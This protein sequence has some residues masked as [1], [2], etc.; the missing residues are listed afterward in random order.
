MP[1]PAE[2]WN[3]LAKFETSE[4]GPLAFRALV[5]LL[6]TW[7]GDDQ[8]AA[9]EVA[10]KLLSKWPDDVRLAPWSW[11]KAASKGVAPATWRLVRA[12]Q[13]GSGHLTK[14]RVSLTRLARRA[15]LEHIT[16][17]VLPR[18]SDDRELSLLYHCPGM[19]PALKRLQATD[20]SDDGDVRALADSPLWQTLE[21]FEIEDLTESFAHLK[22]ASRIVPR[23][24]RLRHVRHL[25]L[26]SPDLIA[27]W[28]SGTLPR[29][30]SAAVFIRSVDEARTL[31]ARKEL[32]RLTSLSISFRCGFSGSSPFEPYQGTIIE[33]D[34]AAADAFFSHA[35]LDRLKS[36]AIVG[37]S[38]GYWGREG[39]GRL[40]L[41]AL[42][43]SGLLQR[44]KHLRLKLLPL[45]DKGVAALAPALGKQLETLELVDV[46]CKGGGA[47]A[48]IDSPCMASLRRL[49]LSAN[50]IDAGHAVRLA[51]VDMPRLQ[52][53]DLS[54]PHVNP[55]YWNV[56]QQPILDAGACAWANSRNAMR[57]R[58][59]RLSNCFLS[60]EA[61]RA[62][63]QSPH[64]RRLEQL[65]LSH[66]S[67][68]AAAIS[69]AVVESPLWRTLRELGL[70]DCRL[71]NDA[72]DALA[73]VAAAPALR[74][75]EL[76][77]NSIG[78]KGA[79]ALARW[80]VLE[81]V[82]R[83]G[84]HDNVIG[85]DGLTALAHSPHL[86]R[87]VELDLEQ[88]CWNS[89]TF[90]FSDQAAR[91]LA[92][93]RSLSRLD[94]L[95]SGCVDEYHGAAYS[96]GFTKEGLDLMRKADWMRPACRAACSDFSKI[97]EYSECAPF[98]EAAELDDHDFRRHPPTLNEA[99]AK[100]TKHKMRQIRSPAAFKPA[101][102]DD[103][104]PRISPLPP[105]P[106]S[107]EPDVI[108]GIAFLD[109][110]PVT[111]H[112]FTLRLPLE[113]NER[114]LPNP[115]G[116]V[117]SDT[118]ASVFRAA[119]LGSFQVGG[120]SSRPTDDG[121]I[122]PIDVDF[123]VG[124]KGNTQRA[125]Q[126]IRESLWWIGAPEETD[127]DELRLALAEE[128]AN[129]ASR[130]L[131]LATPAIVRWKFSGE[132]CY[133]IDRVPFTAQQRESVQG[134]LADVDAVETA[135][136]WTDVATGDGGRMAVCVRYLSDSAEFDTLNVLV[137]TLTPEV[138]RLLHRLM[139][140]GG[141]MLWPMAFAASQEVAQVLDCDWPAVEVVPSAE[142]LHELLSRGP[143]HWWRR[144]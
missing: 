19:F 79:A 137:E 42:I 8:A 51:Q 55:Y 74:S 118:L 98:D 117:L 56:G 107:E 61:L 21:R 106:D 129:P 49:D 22:D 101:D 124:I 6:D 135:A 122:I 131:Q 99:E 23:P 95:F 83:L 138:S 57:L 72:I 43:A 59:L 119:S 52:H 126:L 40:G 85:D 66:S 75:L 70:N 34:E 46:Y 104:P 128:P 48:L 45:G 1:A 60:D 27:A 41:D 65:D 102:D 54:G 2:H 141:F 53:L 130:F 73:R 96:P 26:R 97:H 13:L 133:R 71:D 44:L 92:D 103:A 36:L 86:G 114:P 112:S 88:D 111:D 78:P 115:A 64:L 94:G 14:G 82:W 10:D 136:G 4:P 81:H 77:Y 123:Y 9:I 12:L 116:K 89:R 16:E 68:T 87:L 25:S 62:V 143:Y 125:G 140:A 18:Y 121:R 91:A 5:A 35:R 76:G 93:S 3:E 11:C 100:A 105:E 84:L 33:A 38:M 139:Q 30:R 50:R 31:A 69:Q 24:E 142:S 132:P 39:M 80:P 134:I 110:T 108:E 28:G 127:H 120:G 144:V 90:T 67:F 20:K 113:D 63:F 32:S 17:L 109:P 47:A 7:P 37:Y 58:H 29:L 15:N